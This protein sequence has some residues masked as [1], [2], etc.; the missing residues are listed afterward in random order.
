MTHDLPVT[1]R[2]ALAAGAAA[3]GAVMTRTA[4]AADEDLPWIDAHSHIWPAE[5]DKYPLAPGQTKKDLDPPSFTDDELMKLARPEG[6]G[7]GG[8]DP[9]LG[10]PPVG[11]LVPARR[12]QAA[13]EDVPGA[14]H[15]GR[16]QARNPGRR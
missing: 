5:V 11:Q 7:P 4:A 14:G 15:G 6:V 3:L 8:A 16:P 1:R 2:A 12:G 9:A 13:P 10:L